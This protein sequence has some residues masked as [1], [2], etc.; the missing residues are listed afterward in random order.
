MLKLD[1]SFY[2]EINKE[3]EGSPIKERENIVIDTSNINIG[4]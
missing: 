3:K 1:Q 2:E 4:I